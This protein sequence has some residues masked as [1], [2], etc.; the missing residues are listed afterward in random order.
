MRHSDLVNI[1][2][3]R[4]SLIRTACATVLLSSTFK[5]NTQRILVCNWQSGLRGDR[6][7]WSRS[8]PWLTGSSIKYVTEPIA[9]D[10]ISLQGCSQLSY[11]LVCYGQGVSSCGPGG[12]IWAAS[13]PLIFAVF[14]WWLTI[15]PESKLNSFF[16][17]MFAVFLEWWSSN[18]L[19]S[20]CSFSQ[21]QLLIIF[22]FTFTV[23]V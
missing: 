5:R 6:A 15:K 11:W 21:P 2:L 18:N 4:S 12:V 10:W 1:H 16:I 3:C 20:N 23:Y 19:Y 14:E 22:S 7:L 9:A 8:H 13:T 17:L